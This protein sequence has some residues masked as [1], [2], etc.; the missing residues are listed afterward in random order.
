MANVK[1]SE[2]NDVTVNPQEME[3]LVGYN[4]TG[5]VKTTSARFISEAIYGLQQ[6]SEKGLPNGYV[7]LGGTGRIAS[8]YLPN[9]LSLDSLQSDTMSTGAIDV[10]FPGTYLLSNIYTNTLLQG[11]LRDQYG[12]Y[13]GTHNNSSVKTLSSENN[14]PIWFESYKRGSWSSL[15]YRAAGSDT[16]RT[17]SY[18]EAYYTVNDYNVRVHG[19]FK[20]TTSQMMMSNSPLNPA[21]IRSLPFAPAAVPDNLSFSGTSSMWGQTVTTANGGPLGTWAHFDT[22]FNFVR[23]GVIVGVTQ[24]FSGVDTI[25]V[26]FSGSDITIPVDHYIKFNFEYIKA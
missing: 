19:V 18:Q 6:K 24:K 17:P 15:T 11:L 9:V 5:N 14:R 1:F 2:F 13:G 3:Y 20:V 12:S 4:A 21:A 16:I 8:G 25:S 7:P 10:G 26:A 22:S 23:S